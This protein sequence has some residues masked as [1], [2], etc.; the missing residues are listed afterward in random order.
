[1]SNNESKSGAA[2][3][4]AGQTLNFIDAEQFRN[5]NL[6][7]QDISAILLKHNGSTV[8]AED[9]LQS[10][11]YMDILDVFAGC[12]WSDDSTRFAKSDEANEAIAAKFSQIL[13]EESEVGNNPNPRLRELSDALRKSAKA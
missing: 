12:V 6:V 7:G 4:T 1:M 11:N 8:M 10:A 2:V 3:D 13:T 5:V 9:F